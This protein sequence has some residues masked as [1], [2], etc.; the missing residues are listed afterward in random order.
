MRLTTALM[1]GAGLATLC[2]V[3]CSA[4]QAKTPTAAPNATRVG[5]TSPDERLDEERLAGAVRGLKIDGDFL[6]VD[7]PAANDRAKGESVRRQAESEMVRNVWFESAGAFRDSILLDRTNAK[8]FE[9]FARAI[10]IEGKNDY[11]EAALRTALRL[12]PR[13]SKARYELGMIRQRV[14]DF[15]GAVQ[16]WKTLAASDPGYQDVY[17]RMAIASYYAHDYGSAWKYLGDA[18]RR[19]QAVP[20]QFRGLLSEVAPRP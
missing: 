1:T 10:L 13:F 18:D 19:R 9:G 17:T 4:G 7:A 2:A 12:D 8:S 3:G 6:V 5:A 14:R 16:E 20:P 11:A 15:E